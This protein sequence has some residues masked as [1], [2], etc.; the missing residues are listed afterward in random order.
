MHGRQSVVEKVGRLQDNLHG[1]GVPVALT[2]FL[3]MDL[4]AYTV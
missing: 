2:L 4:T 1:V 3:F